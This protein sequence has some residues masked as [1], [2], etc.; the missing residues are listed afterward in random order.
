[1]QEIQWQAERERAEAHAQRDES[2]RY[3]D[4]VERVAAE[5][6]RELE[7]GQRTQ[8]SAEAAE[9]WAAFRADSRPASEHD[10]TTKAALQEYRPQ[11]QSLREQNRELALS[12]ETLK[13]TMVRAPDSP[14]DSALE[15][16]AAV[17]AVTVTRTGTAV[18]TGTR[19]RATGSRD[20]LGG[21]GDGN[22]DP[23]PHD[24]PPGNPGGGNGGGRPP[25]GDGRRGALQAAEILGIAIPRRTPRILRIIR[26]MTAMTKPAGDASAI[27]GRV[28]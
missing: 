17:A 12:L 8:A 16:A 1:M 4:H 14:M 28:A 7:H 27:A 18:Q 25:S 3:A 19:S 13:A 2:S 24:D 15:V 21:P 9:A 6:M 5:R 20:D 26:R 11:A 23:D 10:E 22:Q